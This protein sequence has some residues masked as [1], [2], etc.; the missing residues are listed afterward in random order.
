MS[1]D[2]DEASQ[3]LRSALL[4]GQLDLLTDCLSEHPEWV[5]VPIPGSP[6]TLEE[7]DPKSSATRAVHFCS[8][9]GREVLLKVVLAHGPDLEVRTFEENKGLT[10]PLVLAAWE[11]SLESCRLLLE[12]GANPQARASAESPLYSAAEHGAFDKV[13]LLLRYGA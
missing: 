5:H 1:P 10:T 9:A 4:K 7:G 12:A 3:A 11:G 6:W 13:D 8:L 2:P